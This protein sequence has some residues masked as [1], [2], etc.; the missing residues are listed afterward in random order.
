MHRYTLS[1][2]SALVLAAGITSASA[3]DVAAEAPPPQDLWYVSLFGGVSIPQDVKT[4]FYGDEYSLD[5]KTGFVVGGAVGRRINDAFR[6][7]G[8]VSY[9]RYSADTFTYNG[10]GTYSADGNVSATYLLAN[11]WADVAHFNQAT[12]Y[13]GGGLGAAYVT[14]DTQFNGSDYGYG[15]GEWGFAGQLGGG[16][17]YAIA[18]NIDLDFGY[19]FKAVSSID[20]D[21]NDG[22]GV[23]E[24]GNLYT[25]SLQLGITAK[26]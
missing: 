14:A 21:D 19:R 9:A 1:G 10:V 25:H 24:D 4:D 15:K 22:Y 16:V 6:V 18:Q 11:V 5:L 3:A 23:Y 26:F 7:E 8:E 20:F 13:L 2:V 12:L 17:T